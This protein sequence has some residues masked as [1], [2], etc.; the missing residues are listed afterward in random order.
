[1]QPQQQYPAQAQYP[2]QPPM[3]QYPQQPQQ[4]YPAPA[5]PAYPQQPYA[6]PQQPQFPVQQPYPPQGYG[7]PQYGQPQQP[8]APPMPPVGLDDY[9]SQPSSGG[10]PSIKW[11]DNLNNPLIGKYVEGFIA[12]PITDADIRPQTNNTGVVQTYRDGRIKAVMVLPLTVAQSEEFPEGQAG[13]WVKGQARDELARAMAEAGAPAG[14]PESGAWI[15]ITLVGVRPIPNMSPAFQFRVE[16][17][18]PNG[19][20]PAAQQVATAT[21]APAIQATPVPQANFAPAQ[22]VQV[23]AQPMPQ[24]QQPAPPMQQPAPGL[25]PAAAA[26]QQA[27]APAP[28]VPPAGFTPDQAALF[29]QLTGGQAAPAQPAG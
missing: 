25:A 28:A 26:P 1:M 12:R 18:R 20:A 8:P 6:Q 17:R 2:G 4:G 23:G 16:Y 29:A 14:A 10:G 7:A 22:Q 5:Q 3:P 15:R 19:A 11:K 21:G 24:V 27:S 13:W 9:W